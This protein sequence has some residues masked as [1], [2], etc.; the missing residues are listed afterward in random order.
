MYSRFVSYLRFC[1]TDGDQI[2]FGVILHVAC[3]ILSIPCLLMPWWLKS[4]GHQQAW[5][6]P[7]KPKYSISSIRRVD[8]YLIHSINIFLTSLMEEFSCIEALL[9]CSIRS[10]CMTANCSST[11]FVEGASGTS[12]AIAANSSWVTGSSLSSGRFWLALRLWITLRWWTCS[13]NNSITCKGK[14][15]Y[16]VR[17]KV[18][19]D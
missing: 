11:C 4:P 13:F 18:C 5:Y 16:Q 19:Q 3:P 9:F 7:N 8:L 1:S 12:L 6:W 15:K 10:R 17:L 2:H 14:K